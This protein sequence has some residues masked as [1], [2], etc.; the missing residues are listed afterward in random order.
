MKHPEPQA[1]TAPRKFYL[2]QRCTIPHCSIN[3][4]SV[5]A[6]DCRVLPDL[7]A[8]HEKQLCLMFEAPSKIR[9]VDLDGVHLGHQAAVLNA[10]NVDCLAPPGSISNILRPLT[11]MAPLFFNLRHFPTATGRRKISPPRAKIHFF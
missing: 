7:S 2:V 9:V 1:T 4:R 8:E 10:W 5:G 3:I 11:A 6:G